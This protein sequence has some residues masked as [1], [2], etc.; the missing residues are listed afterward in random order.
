MELSF[1]KGFVTL[2]CPSCEEKITKNLAWFRDRNNITI[3]CPRCGL[4]HKTEEIRF[5][6]EAHERSMTFCRNASSE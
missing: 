2:D 6:I 4:I 1:D 3:T 5:R